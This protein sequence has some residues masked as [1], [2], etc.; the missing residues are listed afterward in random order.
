M[1]LVMLF[2]GATKGDTLLGRR[3]LLASIALAAIPWLAWALAA[4]AG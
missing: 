1:A 2:V 4:V 3:V